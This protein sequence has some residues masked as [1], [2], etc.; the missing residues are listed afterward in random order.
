M[1]IFC[2]SVGKS[3]DSYVK[4]GIDLFSKRISHYY[5]VEWKIFPQAKNAAS[6]SENDIKKME[7]A[8]ILNALQNDD[9]LVALDEFGQQWT[10]PE[11]AQF[12]Q[13]KANESVKN[14]IFLIGGAYGLHDSV[15]KRS[16]HKWSLSK[17]VFP[18]QLVRLILSEQLYRACTIIRNEK[19][20]HS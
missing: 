13:R 6:A 2:W 18:H 8:I 17:L 19:Y 20:H 7:A 4:E 5:P 15:L 9:I 3:H 1:K 12:I 11:L 10:S 14:I 16:N